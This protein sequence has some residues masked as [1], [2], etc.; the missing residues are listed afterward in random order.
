MHRWNGLNRREADFFARTCNHDDESIPVGVERA[1]VE[2]HARFCAG[3]R[4]DCE[5]IE[6][7]VR[8]FDVAGAKKLARHAREVAAF[9]PIHSVFR[10]SLKFRR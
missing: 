2:T 8:A 10:S 3:P 6:T 5:N 1:F 9:L 4:F 7:T